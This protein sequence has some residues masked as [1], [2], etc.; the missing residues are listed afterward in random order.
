[1]AQPDT[2]TERPPIGGMWGGGRR[3]KARRLSR[4]AVPPP[5]PSPTGDDNRPNQAP[6]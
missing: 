1:M 5:R 4:A 6:V 3:P 2:L